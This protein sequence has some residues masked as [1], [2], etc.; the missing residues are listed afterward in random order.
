M[1]R[2]NTEKPKDAYGYWFMGKAQYE[3][4]NYD[5]ALSNF[6]TTL[7]IHPSWEKDWVQPYYEKIENAK[8]SANQ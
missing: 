8:N 3:L 6:N 5:G 7:E 4:G 1:R 2:T